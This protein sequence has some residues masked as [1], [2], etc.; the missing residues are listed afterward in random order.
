[1]IP[2]KAGYCLDQDFLP[3]AVKVGREEARA[4]CI[5]AGSGQRLHESCLDHIIGTPEDRYRGCRPLCSTNSIIPN[6]TNDIDF[7]FDK[8]RRKFRN[9]IN[10]Q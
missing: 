3:L 9:Q 4:C 8:V 2:P 1:V 7:A 5:A 6:G 10:V